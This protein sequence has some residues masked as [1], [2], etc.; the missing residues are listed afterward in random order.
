MELKKTAVALAF[1]TIIVPP[2]VAQQD[3]AAEAAQ[4]QVI[5][6]GSHIRRAEKEGS[7]PIQS[8]S[9]DDLKKSGYT[10][11]SEVLR[12][13]TA[14]GQGTLSQGFGRAFASGASGISL[15]G[16]NVGAT[17]ILIDGHR[18]AAYPLADDGQRPFVDITSIPFEAVER[19]DI[20]K[21]G[22]SAIYGSDAI[23]GVVNVILKKSYLGSRIT[24]EVGTSEQ[25]GGTTQRA[26]LIHGFG[27]LASDG[28]NAYGGIE[29]RSQG[30]IALSQRSG[31]DWSRS[32]WRGQGGMHLTPG[33]VNSLIP[34]PNIQTPYLFNPHGVVGAN[35][36]ADIDNPANYSFYPGRC[37]GLAALKAGQCTYTDPWYQL[38]APSEHLNLLA[39]VSGKLRDDWE[40]NLK[41]SLFQSRTRVVVGSVPTFP[42]PSYPGNVALGPGITP[43][44]VGAVSDFAVP[45][46]YPGNPFSGP[47][48]VY[49]YLPDLGPLTIDNDSKTLRVVGEINGSLGA[50]DV[51]AA[52]GLT[53]VDMRQ[54]MHNYISRTRLLGLLHDPQPF[55]ITGNNSPAMMAALAPPVGISKTS[56][57]HFIEARG[58]RPLYELAGGPLVLLVGGSYQYRNLASP[59]P[60][61][62]ALG[63]LDS[64]SAV[65]AFGRQKN[66]AVYAELYA[67]VRNKLE[68][69]AALRFDHYDTYGYSTTPKLGFKYTPTNALSLRGTYSHG[70]RA[71]A[72]TENQSAG[73]RFQFNAINDPLT[74]SDG[75]TATAGNVI[76]ACN[77]QPPY[78]QVT[79]SNIQPEKSKALTLGLILEPVQGWSTTLDYYRIEIKDLIASESGLSGYRPEYVRGPAQP[80]LIAD[81]QGGSYMGTPAVGPI[82]YA[83]SAYVNANAIS[84]SG[85]E[86][87]SRFRHRL[88]DAAALTAELQWTHTLS[89]RMRID[90]VSYELAGTHGPTIYSGDTGNP[91]DRVQVTLAYDRGPFNLS[92]SFNWIGGF[93]VLDPS[94]GQG[95]ND[96]C[97]N[98]LQNSNNYFFGATYPQQYCKVESFL[99][100]N[101]SASYQID[102][103]WSVRAAITNLFNQSPPLDLQTYAA[104]GT[105]SGSSTAYNPSLHQAGAI[106]RYFH[107]AASY[108]F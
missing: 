29:Y 25:G 22:A 53:R 99:S 78:L 82:L 26:S 1:P 13:I 8:I 3:I 30:S 40:W 104:I 23:A 49:G 31:Q 72:P 43:Y 88:S 102:K 33:A 103:H 90:G 2:A 69:E 17:L 108:S 86:F 105:V 48:Y 81:G 6:S 85:F 4:Q 50:W 10:T 84:T 41:A 24:A 94:A 61:Q 18:L 47:A 15:R 80:T 9:A 83:T 59:A 63:Q 21:D 67:P 36:A 71:P 39:S 96:T 66:A 87:G 75:N 54:D 57:L 44:Q 95:K 34:Q 91:R 106:G 16:L 27:N 60:Q 92:T 20:V 46:G 11:V 70:F 7:S 51:S 77:F 79:T 101:L 35:G 32:D 93:N 97:E 12:N 74:C 89:Y 58:Q 62:F 64:G 56:E 76:N 45:A 107:L 19:I 37:V 100:T 28:Y 5:I 52:L 42:H 68:L 55:Q 65:Y 38:Q 73:S 14:N 98:S